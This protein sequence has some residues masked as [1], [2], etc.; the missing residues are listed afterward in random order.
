MFECHVCKHVTSVNAALELV[1]TCQMSDPCINWRFQWQ[2]MLYEAIDTCRKPIS[3]A[4][5][6][7]DYYTNPTP[8][9]REL[10]LNL[11][12]LIRLVLI[13]CPVNVI[14]EKGGRSLTA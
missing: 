1:P 2:R 7:Y 12:R 13:S 5:G 6:A 8:D 11:A 14:K 10:A 9:K 3:I 4:P